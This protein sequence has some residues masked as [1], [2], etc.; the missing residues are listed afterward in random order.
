MA[1]SYVPPEI[2][3]A[4]P[5]VQL[6]SEEINRNTLIWKNALI[7]YVLGDTPPY[8]YMENY[9]AKYW[10]NAAKPEIYLHEDGFFIVKFQTPE[11]RDKIVCAGPYMFNNRPIIMKAWEPDFDIQKEFLRFL[12]L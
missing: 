8:S 12:P 6:D 10:N 1:L 5:M 9:I 3:N 11:D 2:V 4:K 7:V